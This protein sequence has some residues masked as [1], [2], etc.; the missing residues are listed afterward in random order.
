MPHQY[1]AFISY[2]RQDPDQTFARDLLRCLEKDGYKVAIDERDFRANLPWPDEMERC[3]KESRFTLT[4]LSPRFRQ[5]GNC[6]EETLIQTV[7]D[8]RQRE[9]RLI[10]LIIEKV[11]LPTLIYLI[12]G[13]DY[14]VKNPLVDP[15]ERLKQTLGEPLTKQ[16]VESD[17][18]ATIG[19]ENGDGGRSPISDIGIQLDQK[20]EWER[21]RTDFASEASRY[22]DLKL[23]VYF[24]GQNGS[25]SDEKIG[26]PNHVISLWQYFGSLASTETLQRFDAMSQT[27]FGI[28]GAE[29]SV[30]AAVVGDQ[31]DLFCR[32]ASRAGSLF[33]DSVTSWLTFEVARKFVEPSSTL[34]PIYV[35][36][37]NAL[38]AWL[39]FVLVV[40]ATFQPNRFRNY[41]LAV[42]PFTASLAA[43]ELI[44]SRTNAHN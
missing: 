3:L 24:V 18:S 13:I 25:V 36:N 38:A 14:T 4:V 7:L 16:P 31:K 20:P 8:L 6:Q 42:D 41:T 43:I 28:T 27:S 12:T 9:R 32:M 5:S 15:Y 26:K 23:S 10:P 33:P 39:N 40:T 30:F 22:H 21:L 2:R 17:E 11:E 44:L 1:D 37:P 19:G 29:L 35:C 34:K